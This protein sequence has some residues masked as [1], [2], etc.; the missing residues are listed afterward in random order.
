MFLPFPSPAYR[1][2][3]YLY[4]QLS[5]LGYPQIPGIRYPN[6]ALSTPP[7]VKTPR[8]SVSANAD[9]TSR[10]TTPVST[11]MPVNVYP[12]HSRSDTAISTGNAGNSSNSSPIG[13]ISSPETAVAGQ[14][15]STPTVNPCTTISNFQYNQTAY[16][17]L[18]MT[19]GGS[20]VNHHY[21]GFCPP[22]PPNGFFPCNMGPRLA[23]PGIGNS[24]PP[25]FMYPNQFPIL[26]GGSSQ[27]N[28]SSNCASSGIMHQ[29]SPHASINAPFIPFNAH[30]PSENINHNFSTLSKKSSTC[31]N[32]GQVGHRGTECT[33]ASI[34]EMTKNTKLAS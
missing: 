4:P 25:D 9:K 3:R 6:I 30:F 31:Y 18:T 5:F 12:D 1:P 8:M 27:T 20:L 24:S 26:N 32:C 15:V 34:D 13:N 2:H 21:A 10:E 23:L 19:P 22:N 7:N 29:P 28:S 11:L 17:I 14:N 16:P 33:E